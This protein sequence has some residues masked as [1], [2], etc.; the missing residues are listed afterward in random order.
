MAKTQMITKRMA[1]DKT[2]AQMVVIV[3]V[4]SLITTFC[5]V[6]AH[7]LLSQNAYQARVTTAS[8]KAHQQLL[9]NIQAYTALASSY[10]TFVSKPTNVIGGSSSG[11]GNNQGNNAEIVLDS[12]PPSYD[13]PALATSVAKILANV[14]LKVTSINGTDDQINQQSNKS[15]TNPTPVSMPFTFTISNASYA[16]VGQL[17]TVLQ[18]SIRP[19]QIDTIN[20]SGGTGNMTMTVSAHTYYQPGKSVNIST[21][22]VK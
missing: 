17:V 9:Q 14:N 1:I 7:A 6:A 19:I 20:L 11:N 22:V 12:L 4:A 10:N 21:E 16:S 15:S 13:F 3:G 8:E 18:Q 5:L 2:N